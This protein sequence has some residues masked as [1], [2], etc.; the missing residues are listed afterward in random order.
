MSQADLSFVFALFPARLALPRPV[1][2]ELDTFESPTLGRL[3]V[4]GVTADHSLSAAVLS[5]R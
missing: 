1:A 4:Q 3:W 5:R 2:W